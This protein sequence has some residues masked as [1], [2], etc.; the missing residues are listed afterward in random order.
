[1]E[2]KRHSKRS[3]LTGMLIIK[4]LDSD[5]L[6]EVD[7]TITDVSKHGVGF[8][9]SQVLTIGAVYETHL[10]IWTKEVIHAFLEIVR[11]EKSGDSFLYGS[12]FI[13]MPPTEAARI[14]VYQSFEN[15][16]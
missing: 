14:E 7:I 16:K 1:M 13:G 2:E 8:R 15:L 4:R 10:T 9:S 11:V 3:E 6:D 12:I 5:T